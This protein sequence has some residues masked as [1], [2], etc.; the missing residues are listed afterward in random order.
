[1]KTNNRL[2]I[3]LS[4]LIVS[5][6]LIFISFGIFD[7]DIDFNSEVKPIINKKCIS[8][9]GGVK[10]EA[11]FSLLF[12]KDA[13]S[14]TESGKP[15][16]IPGDAS[17]S[18]MIKRIKSRDPEKRMPYKKDP[19]TPSEIKIL[20]KWINQGAKWGDHWAYTPVVKQSVTNSETW[21]QKIYNF[22]RGNEIEKNEIDGFVKRKMD[23]MNLEFEKD[24]DPATL[25]RRVSLDIT[26]LPPSDNLLQRFINNPNE[27][28]YEKIVDSLLQSLSYGE[29]MASMWMDLAR[30][31][32]T[33]GFEKDGGRNIWRYRDWLIKSFNEDKP[34]N[35]FIIEQIAGDLIKEPTVEQY[36]ATAFHRNTTSNEEGGTDNEEYRTAA[37]IDRVNTTWEAMMG[38]TFSCVQCHSHPYDPFRHEEYYRFMAFFNNTMDEDLNEEY[39]V[40]HEYLDQDS[41]RYENI[42][43][44]FEK[45]T[46]PKIRKEFLYFLR[47][48]EP[49]FN[50][51]HADQFLNSETAENQW[52]IFR[53][54]SSARLKNI[55]FR[56]RESM[57]I[58]YVTWV[59]DG[60]LELH[61]DSLNGKMISRI[62]IPFSEGTWNIIEFPIASING[63]HDLYF[64]YYSASTKKME[65]NSMFLDWVHLSSNFPFNQTLEND[66]IKNEYIDLLK[67]KNVRKT[68]IMLDNPEEMFRPTKIFERGNWMA[69]GNQV[70]AG[71]PGS[72]FPFDQSFPKNRM[73]LA[74]WITDKKNPLTSRTITNRVWSL[75]FGQGIVETLEDLGTQ[76]IQPTHRELLDHLSWKLMYEYNW[77]IK[78]LIKSI[79]TSRTYKQDSRI[80]P[81]KLKKDKFNKWYSRGPKTRLSAEQL[82]D[83]VLYASGILNQTMYGPSVMPIQPDHIWSS[84][85]SGAQWVNALGKDRYRRAVYTYWKRSSPYPSFMNFDAVSRDVC[86]SRRINTNTP[87]QALTLL[88]DDAYLDIA[89]QF[90]FNLL[91]QKGSNKE[92]IEL[93]YKKLT[94]HKIDPRRLYHLLSLYDK[95]LIKFKKDKSATCEMIGFE[96]ENNIPETA[97]LIVAVHT[98]FNLDEVITKS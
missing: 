31:A 18:E 89:R 10:R 95:A 11:E 75:F 24:A 58:R 32:D 43:N 82:R 48:K 90:S 64:K 54:K 22:F 87:L 98:I 42:Q 66:S 17:N 40:F 6:I 67:S 91:T 14:V 52:V 47:T 88:N 50:T 71:T 49:S 53:K 81:E 27:V 30:Y 46:E 38:T 13:L 94:C 92:R 93:A 85:Y 77:S 60:I 97:A 7:E 78:K 70:D 37:V 56:N 69:K 19:L 23:E 51:F 84:P 62:Q 26:G 41:I 12:K 80:T 73:G 61:A 34:Y 57:Y 36:I 39:P 83:Q 4:V 74:L 21:F 65:D 96:A 9:H 25:L 55:P 28:E 35:Q 5:S 1:M 45:N 3:L 8:C 44:W 86:V 33:K 16:I 29:R 63:E 76:G 68:P 15:S 59:K 2:K 79:V 72:L 20:E